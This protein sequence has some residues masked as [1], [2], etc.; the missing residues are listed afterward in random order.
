M[1]DS[2]TPTHTSGARRFRRAR[3]GL[4]FAAVA[5]TAAATAAA[6]LWVSL[7][8]IE[9]DPTLVPAADRTSKT[10]DGPINMLL[11][12][13]DEPKG[14]G[15]VGVVMVLHIDADRRDAQVISVPRELLVERVGAEPR[16]LADVFAADGAAA[17]AEAVEQCLGIRVQHVALAWLSGMGRLIDLLGGVP[18]DNP[19]DAA[20]GGFVFPRGEITLSGDE[21]LAYLRDGVAAGEFDP[22]HRSQLVLTGIVTRLATSGAM[23]NPG[24]ARAVLDQLA[25][26]VVVDP[27]LDNLRL[28]DLFVE[29][30]T[31]LAGHPPSA[32]RLPTAERGALPSGLRYVVA[33]AKRAAALGQ[34]VN[35][36]TLHNWEQRP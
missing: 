35:A 25:T 5:V 12:S 21:A 7:G 4:L 13:T 30:R 28:I 34:A 1:S 29:L 31:G 23:V 8:A 27:G 36:D 20:S 24:T 33:D 22:A 19:S 6:S 3:G 11:I 17:A 10:T 15:A 16:V 2:R 26:D 18:V 9:R 14:A 32:I